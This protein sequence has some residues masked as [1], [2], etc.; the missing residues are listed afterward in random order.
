ML[1][2]LPPQGAQ[3]LLILDGVVW[4]V[5]GPGPEQPLSPCLSG[6]W[7]AGVQVGRPVSPSLF[8]ETE[9][10]AAL[11]M[12]QPE[13]LGRLLIQ[14]LLSPGRAEPREDGARLLCPSDPRYDTCTW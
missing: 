4:G 2:P 3:S 11:L 13:L 6:C 7:L 8:G 14:H 5:P 12:P 10:T 9:E 1:C